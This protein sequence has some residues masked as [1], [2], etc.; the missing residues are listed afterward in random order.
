MAFSVNG[1]PDC[2]TT[3]LYLRIRA[4]LFSNY[5]KV[6]F[7]PSNG[8]ANTAA[9]TALQ[10]AHGS[11]YGVER[12]GISGAEPP[13]ATCR[14]GGPTPGLSKQA[15]SPQLQRRRRIILIAN[16]LCRIPFSCRR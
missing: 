16:R 11:R 14:P 5:Q 7:T 1:D 6:A 9:S 12:P 2:S 8:S 4:R 15:P 3:F 13:R 10:F